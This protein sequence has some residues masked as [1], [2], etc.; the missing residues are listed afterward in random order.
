MYRAS[1]NLM[2]LEDKELVMRAQRGDMAAFEELI[3]RYDR[4]ILGMAL[5]FTNDMDQAQDLYQEIFL[6]I[7]NGLDR[8]KLKSQFS[9]WLYRVATNACLTFVSDQRKKREVSIDGGSD[10]FNPSLESSPRVP[11]ALVSDSTSD[12]L[13]ESGEIGDFIQQALGRL[14]PQQRLVFVLR[15]YDGHKLKDIASILRCAEGTVK[16]H[17]FTATLRMREELKDV[18][19]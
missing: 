18:Y 16:K 12:R 15:H 7:H 3:Y 19:C 13:A 14:S 4:R 10:S 17:L 2:A 9:T 1:K 11:A 8:F 6:R 5:K